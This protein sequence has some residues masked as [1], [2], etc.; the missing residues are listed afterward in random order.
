MHN[1]AQFVAEKLKLQQQGT[2][3]LETQLD[4]F[5]SALAI[6]ANPAHFLQLM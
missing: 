6:V 2:L 5:T 3:I 1:V 4:P